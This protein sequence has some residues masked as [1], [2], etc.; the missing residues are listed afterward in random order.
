MTDSWESKMHACNAHSIRC[1]L[2]K[3][4]YPSGGSCCLIHVE[5]QPPFGLRELK[6]GDMNNVAP[7]E[8][9]IVTGADDEP[10]MSGRVPKHWY[11]AN[12]RNGL[13]AWN[14]ARDATIICA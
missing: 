14:E 3:D 9:S 11:G 4:A 6:R 13:G 10:S 8:H 1:Y 5:G 7:N 2:S 12:P